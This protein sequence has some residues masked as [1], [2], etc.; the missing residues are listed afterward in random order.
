MAD[1]INKQ[2]AVSVGLMIV[3]IA[4][5]IWTAVGLHDIPKLQNE[6]SE[7]KTGLKENTA[8]VTRLTYIWENTPTRADF[9]NLKKENESLRLRV[10]ILEERSRD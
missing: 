2:S 4:A 10:T 1:P 7:V 3:I 6:I 9:E 5:A 8:A